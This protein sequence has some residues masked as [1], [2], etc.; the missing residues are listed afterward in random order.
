MLAIN[1]INGDQIWEYWRDIPKD[2]AR[3]HRRGAACA[4]K[5][6]A[7]YEDMVFF[8]APDG[9]IVAL[10]AKTGKVRWET[11]VHD[12]KDQTQS[13]SAPIVA[14]G[15]VITGRTCE[16]R[17][18]CFIA[19]HDAKTGKELW[20]FYNTRR[21]RR[22]GWRFMGRCAARAADCEQLGPAGFLRSTAQGSLLGDLK[23]KAMDAFETPRQRRRRP[24]RR[25]VRAL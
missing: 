17:V 6:L 7:I 9:F 15:K 24:A 18:G 2:M 5:N 11:K 3:H 23:S 13:T 4:S 10:D 21:A 19:A 20:K 1:A 22:T 8:A 16:K 12:Y 14:D 25:S